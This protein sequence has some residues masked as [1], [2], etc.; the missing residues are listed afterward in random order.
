ME[1]LVRDDLDIAI[2]FK[3]KFVGIVVKENVAAFSDFI[4]DAGFPKAFGLVFILGEQGLAR[5]VIIEVCANIRVGIGVGRLFVILDVFLVFLVVVEGL[6]FF[7]E[8]D[9]T[10][11][12]FCVKNDADIEAVKKRVY[13]HKIEIH[14]VDII[15]GK[16]VYIFLRTRV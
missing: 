6:N 5:I 8:L 4:E 9:L 16:C 14:R 15:F 3:R 1:Y 12:I 10:H 11:G 13:E 2:I 7:G